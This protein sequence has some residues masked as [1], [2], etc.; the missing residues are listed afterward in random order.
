M[1]YLIMD[2]PPEAI[3]RSEDAGKAINL[4]YHLGDPNG[5]RYVW[6][7]QVEGGDNPRAALIIS[8]FMHLLSSEEQSALVDELPSDW[9]HATLEP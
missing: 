9:D 5:C 6:A 4:G 3:T 8:A 2:S 7:S 1:N